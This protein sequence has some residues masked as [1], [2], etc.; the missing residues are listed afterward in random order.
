MKNTKFFVPQNRKKVMLKGINY[1]TF[2]FL[3]QSASLLS[4]PF[5]LSLFLRPPACHL[6]AI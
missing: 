6:F 1:E 4:L 2:S 5:L 3:L